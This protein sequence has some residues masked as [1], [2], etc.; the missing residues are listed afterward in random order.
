VGSLPAQPVVNFS[1]ATATVTENGSALPVTITLS[2]GW[3]LP[4]SVA[5]SFAGSAS[6][7]DYTRS[8][9][10]LTFAPGETS[11]SITITPKNDTLKETSESIIISLGSPTGDA[12]VGST[13]T[14]AITIMDDDSVPPAP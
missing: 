11:K 4:V 13:N 3:A 6:T 9:T 12:I 7:L 1:Q 14:T 8:A 2:S 5:L 10:S